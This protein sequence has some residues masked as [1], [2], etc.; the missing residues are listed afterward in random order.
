MKHMPHAIA[1]YDKVDE[2]PFDFNRKLP[3]VVVRAGDPR[4][5]A[6]T[7]KGFVRIGLQ[8]VRR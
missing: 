8:L 7:K 3:S 5:P 1:K 6:R 2:I 4:R